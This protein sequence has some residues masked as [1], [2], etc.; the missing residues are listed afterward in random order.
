MEDSNGK[1]KINTLKDEVDKL[2]EYE[3]RLNKIY[4]VSINSWLEQ[5]SK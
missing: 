5:F 2:V 3:R 4:Q 1:P